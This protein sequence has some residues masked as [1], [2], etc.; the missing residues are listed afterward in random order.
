MYAE[1]GLPEEV[2]QILQKAKSA[3]DE[4]EMFQDEL[5]CLIDYDDMQTH[6]DW[7]IE[8]EKDYIAM[9]VK[10]NAWLDTRLTN[11][12]P[13]APS[14]TPIPVEGGV[15]LKSPTP[16]NAEAETFTPQTRTGSVEQA[17]ISDTRE[18]MRNN[19]KAGVVDASIS[20]HNPQLRSSDSAGLQNA[21]SA[22]HLPRIEIEKFKGD[23]I[24]YTTFMLAFDSQIRA[25]ASS[26]H[27]RLY[28]LFQHLEGDPKDLVR[29]ALHMP[30][31]LGFA[32]ALDE[33]RREYGTPHV[34]SNAYIQKF[35]SFP[36]IKS[37]DSDALRRLYL[38]ANQCLSAMESLAGLAVL[39][40]PANMQSVVSKL[41]S[42]LQVRW[43]DKVASK[44]LKGYSVQF[45]DLVEFLHLASA[46]VNDPVYG[47]EAMGAKGVAKKDH[48][49]RAKDS[50][51]TE[52]KSFVRKCWFCQGLHH[53]DDCQQFQAEG[54][55]G[56]KAFVR[57]KGLCYGCYGQGHIARECN[58]R[59]KCRV[60]GKGHP[61][62]M[63]YER[64]PR[65]STRDAESKAEAQTPHVSTQ[66]SSCQIWDE[67]MHDS[68]RESFM[69]GKV[70]CCVCIL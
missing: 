43:R 59:C 47:K 20:L 41:P 69:E 53:L 34:V 61:S 21:I 30:P 56:R 46:S 11:L 19:A 39:D 36:V 49:M 4:I 14:Q 68:P 44:H 10:A 55:D 38:L 60:C 63:H 57:F 8:V 18:G 66:S 16:L 15:D 28:Y 31:E 50:F 52:A 42:Y 35:I 5:L 9:C 65:V 58:S 2:Q 37:D 26:D 32:H 1:R 13:K 6:E 45:S 62:T 27:D 23:P 22:F 33:L 67:I 64:Y 54:I 48:V 24:D 51:V 29:G 17:R 25:H 12:V 40:F 70:R 3:F 7:L